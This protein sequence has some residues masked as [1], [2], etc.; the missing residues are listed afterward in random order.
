M[1]FGRRRVQP[2]HH[3]G[4]VALHEPAVA[5]HHHAELHRQVVSVLAGPTSRGTR[6]A[7]IDP[8]LRHRRVISGPSCHPERDARDSCAHN[9]GWV[10]TSATHPR[11]S[12][13]PSAPRVG[14]GPSGARGLASVLPP[15]PWASRTSRTSTTRRSRWM[16][17]PTR[18]PARPRWPSRASSRRW[19]VRRA[20]AA[21]ARWGPR[22][23]DLDLLVFGR[24]RMPRAP[25]RRAMSPDAARAGVQWL[26]VPHLA[27]VERPSC[28]HRS[29]TLAPGLVPPGWGVS[30]RVAL[31]RRPRGRGRMRCARSRPGTRRPAARRP[32][33]RGQSTASPGRRKASR[34]SGRQPRLDRT[35]TRIRP[36]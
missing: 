29:P 16:S 27:A 23:L 20:V 15:D 10:R 31:R 33:H 21:A 8:V 36:A 3:R 1:Y 25:D 4:G 6:R 5:I 35:G 12:R 30:V 19:S 2:E 9:L 34:A 11:R 18:M 22:E 14:A 28:W 13:G 26:E 17:G 24:H 32:L 7:S